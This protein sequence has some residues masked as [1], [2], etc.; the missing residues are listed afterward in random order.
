M[1]QLR[2]ES[3]TTL[4]VDCETNCVVEALELQYCLHTGILNPSYKVQLARNLMFLLAYSQARVHI[5]PLPACASTH[6]LW[7]KIICSNMVAIV[8]EG[9]PISMVCD[10]PSLFAP[11][12]CA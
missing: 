4:G 2:G 11:T 3:P 7:Y 8:P 9:N 5:L 1:S 12:Q 10:L 6:A